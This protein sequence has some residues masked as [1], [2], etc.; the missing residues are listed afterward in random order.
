MKKN[1]KTTLLACYLGFVTQAITANFAPLLFLKFH[2]DYGISLGQIALIPTA[3]F[4]TQLLVD[5]FCARFVDSIGYRR[6]IVIS[7]KSSALGL[8]GLALFALLAMAGDLGGAVGPSL[9]G[10]VSQKAGNN[11]QAGMLAG[12]VFPLVLIVALILL[13]RK[14]ADR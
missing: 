2:K 10:T 9:I 4:L 12:C 1:Y 14:A 8:A 6:C 5:A 11:L 3:F 13:N 7:E